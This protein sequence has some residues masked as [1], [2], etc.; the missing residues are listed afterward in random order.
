MKPVQQTSKPADV[1]PDPS[2][3]S[4]LVTSVLLLSLT[5]AIVNAEALTK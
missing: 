2:N 1:T 4:S 5:L 3:A